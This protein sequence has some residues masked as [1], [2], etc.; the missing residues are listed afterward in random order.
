MVGTHILFLVKG[1]AFCANLHCILTTVTLGFAYGKE[2]SFYC[3]VIL[4]LNEV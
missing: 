2:N 1:V 4:T 3:H